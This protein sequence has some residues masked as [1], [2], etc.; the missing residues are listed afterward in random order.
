MLSF[1][2]HYSPCY[3]VIYMEVLVLQVNKCLLEADF[4]FVYFGILMYFGM[5][6]PHQKLYVQWQYYQTILR[7]ILQHFS[8]VRILH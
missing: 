7:P 3:I 1:L 8:I 2:C 4:K 6:V 5:C